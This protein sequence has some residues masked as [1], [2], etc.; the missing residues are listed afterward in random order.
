MWKFCTRHMS[1]NIARENHKKKITIQLIHSKYLHVKY[2]F[3]KQIH[4]M[5]YCFKNEILCQLYSFEVNVIEAFV[6]FWCDI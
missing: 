3:P 6:K 2:A 5:S 1:S 4:Q